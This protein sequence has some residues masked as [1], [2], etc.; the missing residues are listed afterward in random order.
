MSGAAPLRFLGLVLGG[1]VAARA[2]LLAPTLWPAEQATPAPPDEPIVSPPRIAIIPPR[3]GPFSL[4]RQEPARHSATSRK[5]L[6][7]ARRVQSATAV[8][9]E[10]PAF[11]G[12]QPSRLPLRIAPA[13]R[14][15]QPLVSAPAIAL[16]S[17]WSGSA[18]TLVRRGESRQLASA[19][20]LGGSQVGARIAYRLRDNLSLSGRFYMPLNEPAG[21]EA[22][23]GVEWQP[24]RTMPLRLLAE[25][26]QAIGRDGR[27]AFALL[28]HGGV[29]ERPVLGP[30]M[31]DAYA[32]AGL[33]GLKSRD[34][35][36]DGAARLGVPLADDLI[37]GVGA[38]GAAQPGAARLD[39]G[40]HASYRLP[41]FGEKVRIAAEWRVRVAGDARPGSGPA[42][43]LSTDF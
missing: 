7:A 34:Q 32:Q 37:V 25:R 36:A 40:P 8:P 35:F 14:T 42:F 23:L 9:L 20:T 19:G 10:P 29:S 30:L 6:G 24:V 41:A 22:A 1:W 17:R 21:A 39:V 27:S 13:A 43:T 12:P 26:R 15:A 11:A 2:A 3:S 33:V 28:A 31:L 4:F 5:A 16:A 38:W 18:W